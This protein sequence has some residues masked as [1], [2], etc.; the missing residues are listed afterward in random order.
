MYPSE[1]VA[2]FGSDVQSINCFIFLIQE[3]TKSFNKPQRADVIYP[4][5]L[6]VRDLYYFWFAPTLCYEINFPRT[7]MIRTS[8][9][10]KRAL[11]VFVCSQVCLCIVQQYIMPSVVSAL[12]PFSNMEFS[13]VSER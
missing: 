4:D 5:N 12:I 8:F 7:R 1:F 6:T 10:L 9:L 11:E 3:N 2:L 13:L